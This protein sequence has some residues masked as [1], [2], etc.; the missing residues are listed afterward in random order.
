[1][2]PLRGDLLKKELSIYTFGD[3][4]EHFPIRHIDKT[5]VNRIADIHP[6]TEYIQVVGR[7]LFFETVGENRA[8]RLVAQLRDSSGSLE[9]AWFQGISWVQKNLS[10]GVDYLVFGKVGFFNG[11]HR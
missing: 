1:M 2:G 7:L 5:K 3:L 11:S 6:D 9:L 4:L 10:V 8:K